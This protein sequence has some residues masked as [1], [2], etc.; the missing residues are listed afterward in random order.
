M[1]ETISAFDLPTIDK[2]PE[3]QRLF[4]P[5]ASAMPADGLAMD[6]GIGTGYTT[7]RVFG[8]RPTVCVDLH[9]PNLAYYRRRAPKGSFLG[10]VA[11][12]DALPIR[13]EA[14]AWALCSEVLEHLDHDDR[15]VTEIARVLRPGG[16]LVVTVPYSGFGTTGLPE[17]LHIKTVHDMPGP[18]FHVRPG[19]D[20]TEMANLLRQGGLLPG[21]PSFYLRAFTKI[22]VDL[23]SLAH[24][25]YQRVV[26]RRRS[27]TWADAADAEEGLVFRCYRG[28]FPALARVAALDR[29]LR[30]RRGFGL[31]AYGTKPLGH[32]GL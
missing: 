27:W 5:D 16:R 17:L 29:H 1:T 11:H 24:L 31:I 25:T 9:L 13:P 7:S 21:P 30:S 6:I 15:A 19:Y 10:V 8:S 3:I 14:L 28:I 20:E 4:G 26:H 18:E 12:A 23:I 2:I 22:I 32:D